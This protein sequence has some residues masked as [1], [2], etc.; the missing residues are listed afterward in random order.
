MKT[1]FADLH[2]HI[3][4]AGHQAVKITAS[5][6]LQLKTLLYRDAPLKGLDIIGVVDAAC[7][8]V[9]REITELVRQGDLQEL[10]A[11]GF[12]ARNGVLLITAAEV[13]STEGVHSIIYM[14]S[15]D[16]IHTYQ[17]YL[18]SRV[19]NLSLSTQKAA[20]NIRELINL[21]ILLEG[22]YCPAHAFTPHKGV[23][24]CCTASLEQLLERDFTCIKVLE[25]GLSSDSDMADL[26][27][28]CRHFNFLS[29]SDAHSPANLGREYNLLRM[30]EKNFA[31]LKLCLEN[32]EGRKIIANYGMDPLM[33]KYHRSYCP[34]C[35]LIIELPAPVQA[36]PECQSTGLI[37]G[38]YD[39]IIEIK[40]YEEP[41]HPL[42]R[43][44]YNYR[45][46][47]RQLPGVGAKKYQALLQAFGSEIELLERTEIEKI[48][49]VG[50][51]DLARIIQSMRQERLPIK[52]GGGGRYGKVAPLKDWR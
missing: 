36:C 13:E 30:R 40:N 45:V 9:E 16:S 14:P 26:L 6:D 15:L 5:R 48:A 38:V 49:R 22:I 33:G 35:D 3:G 25:L 21:S 41:H 18:G 20:T 27:S 7:T 31:E 10:A 24:G 50:G 51:S 23:Y 11:G 39:R 17:K 12:L 46:P 8:P 43:P 32:R 47:L 19:K 2:V 1:Y 44:I 4:Q 29:N 37:N 28:E 34:S 42:F 52:P